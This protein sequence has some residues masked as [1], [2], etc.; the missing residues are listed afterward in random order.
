MS[1]TA[2]DVWKGRFNTTASEHTYVRIYSEISITRRFM[3]L[4]IDVRIQRLSDHPVLLSTVKHGDCTSEY[5][6][7]SEN[8]G[9]L[10]C[11]ITEAPLSECTVHTQY[12]NIRT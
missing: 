12:T 9:L 7:I 1:L 3:G 4:N 5:G 11:W 2:T 8:V 10:R 6:Q